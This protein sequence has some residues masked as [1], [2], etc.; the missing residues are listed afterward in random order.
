[1]PLATQTPTPRPPAPTAPGNP[2]QA[3]YQA[4]VPMASVPNVIPTMVYQ[5]SAPQM[6]LP[7]GGGLYNHPGAMSPGLTYAQPPQQYQQPQYRTSGYRGRGG[8]G[9]GGSTLPHYTECFYCGQQGHWVWQCPNWPSRSSPPQ[10]PQPQ[11]PHLGPPPPGAPM[12]P[13]Q[14]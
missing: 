14:Q 8:R 5:T 11:N 10:Q 6:T 3:V 1:M 13:P 4:P 9:R 12:Y 2:P 7:P